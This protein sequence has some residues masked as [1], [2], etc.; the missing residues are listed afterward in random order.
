M[1]IAGIY[2][3][4]GGPKRFFAMSKSLKLEASVTQNYPVKLK[5]AY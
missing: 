2:L 4:L 3:I 1:D 5:P